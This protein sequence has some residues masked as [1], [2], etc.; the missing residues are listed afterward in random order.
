MRFFLK[1]KEIES[2]GEVDF[3]PLSSSS[4]LLMEGVKG[5]V[6][7]KSEVSLCFRI[8]PAGAAVF[9]RLLGIARTVTHIDNE[10]ASYTT[11]PWSSALSLLLYSTASVRIVTNPKSL[12][13]ALLYGGRYQ[14][15]RHRQIKILRIL[16]TA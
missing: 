1:K 3:F 8:H 2:V 14:E 13:R 15:F 5:K 9:W 12:S 4:L 10:Y 6:V 7:L 11:C 16:L